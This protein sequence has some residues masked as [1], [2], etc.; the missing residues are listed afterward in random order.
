MTTVRIP[1]TTYSIRATKPGHKYGSPGVLPVRSGGAGNLRVLARVPIDKIPSDAT[2]LSATVE[3]YT[4]EGDNHNLS[5]FFTTAMQRT[6][7]F[8]EQYLKGN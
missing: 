8:Y 4:Y 7:A 5:G 2:I 3:F 1:L 6:L